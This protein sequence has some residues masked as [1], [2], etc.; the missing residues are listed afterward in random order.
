MVATS[1]AADTPLFITG[2]VRNHGIWKNWFW[3][4][5]AIG[6][7]LAVFVFSRYWRRA[8]VITDVELAELR[9]GGPSARILRLV[10]GLF[11]ALVV[12]VKT[13]AWVICGMVGIISITMR[14]NPW[15]A[16][17]ICL[18]V[19][20]A[21]SLLSGFWGVVVTD[22]VQFALAMTGSI[23][24][25][26]IAVGKVGGISGLKE[27]LGKIPGGLEKLDF[28]PDFGVEGAFFSTEFWECTM[29]SFFVYV[30]VLWWTKNADG[31]EAVIQRINASKD[32]RHA[33]GATMFF[34]VVNNAIRPWPWILVALVSLVVLREMPA[35]YENEELAYPL[36]MREFLPAGLMGVMVASLLAAFM[37]TVDTYLN[38]SGAYLVNDVYRRFL[39]KD[40]RE[41]H[42]I[43][44][45]RMA[46]LVIMLLAA[47]IAMW[48]GSIIAIFKMLISLMAGFG[49]VLLVRWFY[50]RINAWSEL[51]AMA[52]S[53]IINIVFIIAWP[54]FPFAAQILIVVSL[55]AVVWL[56]AT[57]LTKPVEMEQLSKFY[58]RVRPIGFWGPVQRVNPDVKSD[59]NWLVIITSWIAGFVMVFSLTFALGKFL[60]AEPSAGLVYTIVFAASTAFVVWSIMRKKPVTS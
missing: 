39:V 50:W 59:M 9:Y 28:F 37:S 21:Y 47:G 4:T 33:F 34:Q 11:K 52:G 54:E 16:L 5:F 14:V 6:G 18:G 38:L 24:L 41:S 20:L 56:L 15:V 44:V 29:V 46:I 22:I 27:K 7:M 53:I 31:N 40:K 43:F 1:F 2:I 13:M 58:C 17:L 10:N 36:M 25:A 51:S 19:A 42:Y 26:V 57:F 30:F 48:F 60:L 12:N 45:S 32:E 23:A 35:G 3:W 55:S 49:P 8:E